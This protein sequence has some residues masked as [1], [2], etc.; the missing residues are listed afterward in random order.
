MVSGA[1][2]SVWS[3]AGVVANGKTNQ[4]GEFDLPHLAPGY[5]RVVVSA[6]GFSPWETP[7]IRIA[8]GQT[9]NL[10][11]SLRLALQRQNIVVRRPSITKLSLSPAQNAG[12][13]VIQGQ[14]M[15]DFSNDPDELLAQLQELAGPAVGPNGGTIYIDGFSG[16]DLP[17]KS[18][19]LAVRVNRDPFT[20]SE[21]HLGYGRIEIITKPGQQHLH[22]GASIEANANPWNARSPFLAG[23]ALPAYHTLLYGAHA[24]GSLG[25]HTSWF[26]SLQRRNINHDE[27]IH[28]DTLDPATLAIENY[29][30]A[31]TAPRLLNDDSLRLD[32]Q[33][34]SSNTLMA[35]Y[36]YF[37]ISMQNNGVGGQSLASQANDFVRHHH[38]FQFADTQVLSPNGYNQFRLQV[39]HFNNLQQPVSTQPTLEVLGAFTGGGFSGGYY[40]RSESHYQ[41]RNV[42]AFTW[43]SH[44]AQFG[45]YL[46]N[47]RRS[48]DNTDNFNGTFIFNSLNDYQQT[49]MD[50]RQGMSMQQIRAAGYGPN[51]FNLTMGNPLAAVSRW[52]GALFA[53]DNWKLRPNLNFSYGLRLESENKIHDH[54]DWAPRLGLAWGL[55]KNT[56]IRAGAGIFYDRLDD[57]QM[58]Q[59]ERLNGINQVTYQV[60]DPNF[61]PNVP[62]AATLKT[63]AA[64]PT[65]YIIGPDLKSPYLTAL[66]A[67]IERQLGR[68]ATLSLTYLN[69]HGERQFLTNDINAPLPG[70]YN[71]SQPGSGTRPL[72]QAAGNIYA[73][74]SQGLYRQNQFIANFRVQENA[75]SVF[76]YYTFNDAHADA[77]GIDSF[78]TNPWN[79]M[80]DYG[81]AAFS[82]RHRIFA[83]GNLALPWGVQLFPM[84]I[85]RSGIPFSITLGEDL[86]GTGIHNGRPAPAT[87][88]TPPADLRVTPYGSFNIA[89]A[90]GENLIAPQSA[91][92][93]A[94]VTFNLRLMKSFGIGPVIGAGHGHSGGGPD[95]HHHYH[96]HRRGL[97]PGGLGGSGGHGAGGGGSDHRYNLA[98]NISVRNLFN[99]T[100]LGIP[101][102]NLNSPL[103]GQSINLAGGPFGYENIATRFVMLGLDFSF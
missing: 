62:S 48:E 6:P 19:I 23:A 32:R 84:V 20:A 67:S 65:T 52:D 38:L 17:P 35:R 36:N 43:G 88:T 72:G 53:E 101:V 56:V 96:D 31:L 14:A 66:A 64:A 13:V 83:G 91:T 98:V 4:R 45:E 7:H 49:E 69:S 73:Y 85:A 63:S 82:I 94:A 92:G 33:L 5:Y 2:V 37:G 70:T 59:V 15:Q 102:G 16:G 3:A 22:G 61:Y 74:E 60:T 100:N 95:E 39:L 51:Q 18:A 58:I 12:A 68:H 46:R 55:D 79:L 80:A 9:A 50:L 97:G 27:L 34:T 93:P 44:Q 86:Y 77:N 54:D 42:T 8:A 21:S 29:T 76:G 87:A 26:F 10:S 81:R 47:I 1:Q 25:R 90:P 89:P 57:D 103:F 78:A 11:I 30:A 28:T 99:D 40:H 41:V 71:P 24:G 75:F